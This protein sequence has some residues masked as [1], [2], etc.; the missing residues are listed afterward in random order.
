MS[1]DL[2]RLTRA[3]R[4]SA[5]VLDPVRRARIRHRVLSAKLAPEQSRAS[6]MWMRLAFAAAL[7]LIVSVALGR[8]AAASLPGDP[9]FVLKLEAE[10]LQLLFSPDLYRRLDSTLEHADRRLDDLEALSRRDAARLPAAADAYNLTLE[11]VRAAFDAMAA[12]AHSDRARAVD[13]TRADLD[14][15][16]SKLTELHTV[17]DGDVERALEKAREVDERV[18]EVEDEDDGGE[19]RAAPTA[20]PSQVSPR[21]AA[22]S[23]GSQGPGPGGEGTPAVGGTASPQPTRTGEATHTPD[24]TETMAPE[25]EAEGTKTPDPTRTPEPSHTPDPTRT[26]SPSP[27]PTH[28]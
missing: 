16:V 17:A 2:D 27:S 19:H 3:I 26:P 14:R 10:R 24:P 7:I 9:A 20:S 5:P 12:S 15:H 4:E 13:E 8:A 28:S 25:K 21:T 6:V 22:P 18:R 11:E 1:D 23:S